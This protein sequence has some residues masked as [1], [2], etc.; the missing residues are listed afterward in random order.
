MTYFEAA[1]RSSLKAG[2]GTVRPFRYSLVKLV[3]A[4]QASKNK[5]QFSNVND[6]VFYIFDG[7]SGPGGPQLHVTLNA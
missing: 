4:I 7:F 1:T 6:I 5:F 2:T 3:V